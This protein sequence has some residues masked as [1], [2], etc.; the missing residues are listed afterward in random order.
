MGLL[1]RV[2]ELRGGSVKAGGRDLV[3]PATGRVERRAQ[4]IAMIFQQPRSA[5]NPTMRVGNQLSRVLVVNQR[6]GR[7]EAMEKAIA[8]LGR[9]GIAGSHR[10]ARA[11]PHQLSGG[12]CQ[13]VMIA[14]A[15]ACRPR[16]L[17][18][19]EPTTA[20]DVTVQAQIFDL[21]R[22]LVAET[23]CAVV[24]I[25]HDLA[26]VAEMCD[27]VAVLYGGQVMEVG[28]T[29][30][31]LESPTH[32][33]TRFL[34]D[35]IEREVDPRVDERGVNFALAG[36]RFGHRCPHAYP[37]CGTFP[38]MVEVRPGHSASCFL[39]QDEQSDAVARAD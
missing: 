14:M 33:Y 7:D 32:P 20:L 38:P 3:D 24:L 23:R 9:V 4:E 8:M 10:V 34:L 19:D 39:L 16:V 17:I 31:V 36:C 27:S 6:L 21:I 5:L 18:A 35:A 25:T 13:R 11:Y 28:S 2:I 1:P 22:E 15:L 26:V 30:D 12:M 37:A 29:V